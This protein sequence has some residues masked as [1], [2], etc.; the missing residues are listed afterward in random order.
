MTSPAVQADAMSPVR[1][2]WPLRGFL[3]AV[4]IFAVAPPLGALLLAVAMVIWL[5]FAP[6]SGQEL[7]AADIFRELQSYASVMV[8]MVMFSHLFGG[9][10]AALAA[11]WLGMR[12]FW[13]GT[14]GYVEALL[15]AL[16]ASFLWTLRFGSLD[17]LMAWPTA[18]AG[19]ASAGG[20]HLTLMAVSVAAALVCRWLLRVVRILP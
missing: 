1:R 12:T 4:F 16:L 2:R 7:Q 19:E 13:R 3:V 8:L 9:W 14:F 15:V 11:V 6:T 18:G 17:A 5:G 20:S 10:Q